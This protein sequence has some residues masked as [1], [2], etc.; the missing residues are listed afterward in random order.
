MENVLA[1][2]SQYGPLLVLCAGF[3]D[4]LVFTGFVL[5]GYALTGT[6]AGLYATASITLSQMF[7]A[8]VAGSYTASII[9]FSVGYHGK[10]IKLVEKATSGTKA[11]WLREKLA[12]KGLFVF[13]L[14]CRFITI[15]RPI[16]AVFLGTLHIPVKKY[17][18]YEFMVGT[19]WVGFWSLM[20]LFGA[21]LLMKI[22][23][24]L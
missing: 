23:Q 7:V 24:Y 9:N 22:A 14:I 21:E 11:D 10:K 2:A 6:I 5:Q 17:L 19:I 16:Y 3:F 4:E 13:M 1:F 12:E 15:T 8:A 20:I 18:L